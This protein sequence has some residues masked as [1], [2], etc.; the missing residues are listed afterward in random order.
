MAERDATEGS[1]GVARGAPRHAH[2]DL[3]TLVD[4]LARRPGMRVVLGAGEPAPRQ[5]AVALALRE[6]LNGELEL[7]L[8]KRA[9]YA[10]DPWSGQVALPG[11]RHEPGDPTLEATAVRETFEET[12]VDL[13][14]HGA[15]LGTLDEIYPRT[16]V[17][18]PIVVRP[19]VFAIARPVEL[20]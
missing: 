6:A 4:A 9:D 1:H 12:G 17:L 8:I 11:G 15:P 10:G 14:A 19:H 3:A 2:P 16:P 20:T 5:A 13:A 18:P 7:L